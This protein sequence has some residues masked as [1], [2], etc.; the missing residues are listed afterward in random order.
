MMNAEVGNQTL[1]L[2]VRKLNH[3]LTQIT[4][5]NVEVAISKRPPSTDGGVE[6]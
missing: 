4:Q 2:S 5:M 6:Q 1:A 3:R